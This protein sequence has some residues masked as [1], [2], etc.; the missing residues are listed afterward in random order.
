MGTLA[1]PNLPSKFHSTGHLIHSFN[2]TFIGIGRICDADCKCFSPNILLWY[3]MHNKD[4][5]PQSGGNPPDQNF[6]AFHY[7]R[8][9]HPFLCYLL[10]LKGPPCR[11][12]VSTSSRVWSPW[13]GTSMHHQAYRCMTL[14][15]VLLKMVMTIL[16]QDLPTKML[17]IFFHDR[18]KPSWDIF[19]RL[20]RV[21]NQKI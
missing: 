9:Q 16:G 3:T 14:G 5:S 6:G 15:S 19:S 1:P 21:C 18:M 7:A 2:N 17:L 11:F 20:D 4:P 10:K 12:S 13:S 8:I